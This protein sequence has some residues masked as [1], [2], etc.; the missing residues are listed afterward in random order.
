VAASVSGGEENTASNGARSVQ[1]GN[2]NKATGVVSSIFG[3]VSLT[4]SGS[5]EAIRSK[6]AM[7]VRLAA[8]LSGSGRWLNFTDTVC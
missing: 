3:G 8:R 1:G 2:K 7:C 6:K 5:G 4:A